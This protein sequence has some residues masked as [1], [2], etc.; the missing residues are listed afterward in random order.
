MTTLSK[1]VLLKALKAAANRA[2][3]K[4]SS[5]NYAQ[6]KAYELKV[7]ADLVTFFHF[8]KTYHI[9]C[10]PNNAKRLTFGGAPCKPNAMLYDY[11]KVQRGAK[12]YELWVSVQFTTLSYAI[13]KSNAAPDCSDLHELDI[14]MYRA[15]LGPDY[16]S[17]KKVV[18]AASCK[19]GTWHK[20]Y[21]REALGLR[22][23]LGLLRPGKPSLAPWFASNV[24]TD[25]AS[26]LAL[27]SRDGNSV[28]YAGSLESLGLYVNYYP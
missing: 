5:S 23:E 24:P 22:R 14:G 4:A 28:N 9:S 17:Y 25:P 20:V 8:N 16:P 19:A 10:M 7:L 27:F 12:K 13:G 15:P 3:K 2:K 18:F 11:I 6:G 1:A 21:A 26:P